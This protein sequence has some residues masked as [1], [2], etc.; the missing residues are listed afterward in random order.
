M[1]RI[2]FAVAAVLLVLTVTSGGSTQGAPN[3]PSRPNPEVGAKADLQGASLTIDGKPLPAGQAQT[4][5]LSVDGSDFAFSLGG[6]TIAKGTYK[7]DPNKTPKEVDMVSTG[8]LGRGGLIKGI[9]ELNGNTMTICV[10]PP[11]NARPAAFNSPP[12]SSN[13]LLVWQVAQN[14]AQPART[15]QRN[16]GK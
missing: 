9:Y 6:L 11:G 5:R 10:T 3:S 15:N 8:G 12:G 1:E 4:A 16:T 7:L 14:N 2:L 13:R